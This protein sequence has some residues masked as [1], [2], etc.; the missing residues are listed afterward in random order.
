M[1]NNY[2]SGKCTC[3]ARIW[4]GAGVRVDTGEILCPPCA[5]PV[6]LRAEIA[7]QAKLIAD[8]AAIIEDD[9]HDHKTTAIHRHIRY[10]R[11]AQQGEQR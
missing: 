7:R 3:S 5:E 10:Y 9:D 8:I 2:Q 6:Q 11:E 1:S 4:A